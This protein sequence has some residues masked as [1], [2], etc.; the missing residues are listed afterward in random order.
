MDSI[1]IIGNISVFI[2]GILAFI[3]GVGMLYYGIEHKEDKHIYPGAAVVGA[4][5]LISYSIVILYVYT[6][7]SM[8][9]E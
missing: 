4:M 7:L 9:K 8:L 6:L 2:S 5:Y 1:K 3:A